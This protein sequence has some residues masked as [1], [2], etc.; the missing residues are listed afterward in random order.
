MRELKAGEGLCYHEYKDAA[1]KAED[2]YEQAS[3]EHHG[4][5]PFLACHET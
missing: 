3:A 5:N 2:H 1:E 4:E